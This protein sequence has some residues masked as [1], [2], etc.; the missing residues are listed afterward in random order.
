MHTVATSNVFLRYD[1]EIMTE[2][3]LIFFIDW[4]GRRAKLFKSRDKNTKPIDSEE[5]EKIRQTSEAINVRSQSG[6]V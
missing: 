2:W 1:S 4:H 5:G 6:L 3:D